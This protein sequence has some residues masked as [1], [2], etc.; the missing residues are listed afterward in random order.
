[1][2]RLKICV[3]RAV[4]PV[5]ASEL[6]KDRMR[7]ELLAHLRDCFEEECGRYA[8]EGAAVDRALQRFGHPEDLARALQDSVPLVE[9]LLFTPVPVLGR[10]EVWLDR[11]VGRMR[12]ESPFRHAVR[13]ALVECLLTGAAWLWASRVAPGPGGPQ[14]DPT[15]GLSWWVAAL[16]LPGLGVFAFACL[17]Y[18][19]RASLSLG[20][21]SARSWRRMAIYAAVSSLVVMGLGLE[22]LSLLGSPSA[23]G[24]DPLAP[25]CEEMTTLARGTM[26]LAVFTPPLLAAFAYLS[27]RGLRRRQEWGGLEI[28][29]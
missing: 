25:V 11:I 2:D 14:T 8:P 9:R 10:I 18:G 23:L 21:R 12:G 19:M 28:D 17:T 24:V 27:A 26:A 1:M 6:R 29:V 3:E 15:R 20:D 13:L 22:F 7:S 4:R 5:R 16:T